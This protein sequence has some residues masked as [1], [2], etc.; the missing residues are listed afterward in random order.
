[1]LMRSHDQM[2]SQVEY[3]VPVPVSLV[4]IRSEGYI[5]MLKCQRGVLWVI[6]AKQ[7]KLVYL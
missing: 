4:I 3:K 2:T 7:L 5:H 6:V 1:M